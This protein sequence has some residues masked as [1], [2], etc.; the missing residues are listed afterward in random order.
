M[1][2]EI[3]EVAIRAVRDAGLVVMAW[4]AERRILTVGEGEK[5]KV[6][7]RVYPDGVTEEVMRILDVEMPESEA[8]EPAERHV[9]MNRHERRK[10]ASLA[11]RRP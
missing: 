9:S 8:P 11:R 3:P 2:A 5:P 10:A 6:W 1:S 4:D 7:L